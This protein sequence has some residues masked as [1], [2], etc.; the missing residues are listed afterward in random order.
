MLATE[1][2]VDE[3]PRLVSTEEWS[4]SQK[5]DGQR[6][7]VAVKDGRARAFRRSG[8]EGSLPRQVQRDLAILTG[9]EWLIDGELAGDVLWVFD[10]I[11]APG[12]RMS[13]HTS[14]GERRSGLQGIAAHITTNAVRVLPACRSSQAKQT[15]VDA[16]RSG[17][18]EGVVARHVDGTYEFDTRSRWMVKVKF[19]REVDVVVTRLRVEEKENF[20]IGLM[21]NGELIEIGTCSTLFR[22]LP[23]LAVGQVVT[24]RYLYANDRGHLQHPTRPRLRDDKGPEDCTFEQLVYRSPGVLDLPS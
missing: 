4:F 21:R 6:R 2:D 16:V 8:A 10:L 12:D 17:G 7:M 20:A 22:G 5:I 1:A 3:L 19:F 14:Y 15:L 11:R 23:A 18:G 9:G 13:E 24:V